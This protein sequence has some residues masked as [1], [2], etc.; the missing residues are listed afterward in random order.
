[1]AKHFKKD[2]VWFRLF[3]QFT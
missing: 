1:M 3:F 2:L